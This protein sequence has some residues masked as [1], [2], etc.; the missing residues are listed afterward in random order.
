M[1]S[2]TDRQRVGNGHADINADGDGDADSYADQY[3]Q[4]YA[5]TDSDAVRGDADDD[6]RD[7]ADGAADL[8]AGSEFAG[9]KRQ[10]RGCRT[11]DSAG[12]TG[13]G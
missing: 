11:P 5:D 6:A 8:R 2:F 12:G 9:S 1:L 3:A 10:Q 4:P 13:G 7:Y